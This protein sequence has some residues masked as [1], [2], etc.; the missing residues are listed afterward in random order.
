MKILT[1]SLSLVACFG[2]QACAS[3]DESE[4]SS[5]PPIETAAPT[6]VPTDAPPA[7]TPEPAAAPAPE[8]RHG[9]TVVVA[10]EQ[11]VEVVTHASG[12]V[13]AYLAT[14]TAP[15]ENLAIRV[16]VPV[17]KQPAHSVSLQWNARLERYEG[18]VIDVEIAPGPLVVQVVVGSQIWVGHA[19]AIVIAPAVVVEVVH[20]HK[21]H[22]KHKRHKKHK[23]HKKHR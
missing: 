15:A 1:I 16:E 18:R 5:P 17:A 4:A 10:G 3:D 19:A 13:Y 14:K 11:T 7:P 8:R 22:K 12:E 2:M 6:S 9:G 20:R 21:L 23:K